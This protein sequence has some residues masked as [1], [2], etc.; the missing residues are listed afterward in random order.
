MHVLVLRQ[1]CACCH[2]EAAFD[3]PA[4]HLCDRSVAPLRSR[5]REFAIAA[6]SIAAL[7]WG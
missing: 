4:S 3:K 1:T 7:R 6:S 5:R 2:G